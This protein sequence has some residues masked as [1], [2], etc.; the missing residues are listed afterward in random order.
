MKNL[1]FL[2]LFFMVGSVAIAQSC[3]PE[4]T[5]VTICEDTCD[6]PPPTIEAGARLLPLGDSITKGSNGPETIEFIGYRF[7]LQDNVGIGTYDFVGYYSD[8]PSDPVYD[9]LHS[10]YAGKTAYAI[11][12]LTLGNMLNFFSG[13][14]PNGSAV[15]IHAGTNDMPGSRTIQTVADDVL[16][17]VDIIDAHDPTI[18]VYVALIIPRGNTWEYVY[19]RVNNFNPALESTLQARQG[20][21]ANLYIVDMN[22]AFHGTS[23]GNNYLTCL[24]SDLVHPNTL[25]YQVMADTWPVPSS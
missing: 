13:Y 20:T 17:I 22:A 14:N 3:A 19:N 24:S 15:L 16:G 4:C 11:Q 2:T 21:K 9:V 10:G 7:A 6:C 12:S 18:D 8:P 1:F 25:G 5:P 23:C